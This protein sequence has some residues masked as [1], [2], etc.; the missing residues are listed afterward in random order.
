M[1]LWKIPFPAGQDKGCVGVCDRPDH[2]RRKVMDADLHTI[3][4]HQ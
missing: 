1:E 3:A 4:K 2:D